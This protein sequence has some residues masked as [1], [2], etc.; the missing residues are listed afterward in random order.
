MTNQ[1]AEMVIAIENAK[2]FLLT[3]CPMR[4][5]PNEY[6][7]SVVASY[8]DNNISYYQALHEFRQIERELE[9]MVNV[10]IYLNTVLAGDE[11]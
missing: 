6:V 5:L 8:R 4:E 7:Q 9:A 2:R 3:V 10:N 1:Q 11:E